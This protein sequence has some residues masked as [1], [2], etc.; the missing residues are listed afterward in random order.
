MTKKSKHER[1]PIE[2]IDEVKNVKK[3]FDLESNQEGYRKISKL[4]RL[5][6]E[7]IVKKKRFDDAW[8]W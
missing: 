5:A 4:S 1:V 6:R 8:G 3:I 7:K 2:L